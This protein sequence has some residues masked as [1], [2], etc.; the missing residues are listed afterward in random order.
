ML[1]D[2]F[3]KNKND[4]WST[5]LIV[6]KGHMFAILCNIMITNINKKTQE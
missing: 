2:K 5:S 1:L 3:K 4:Y 6:T